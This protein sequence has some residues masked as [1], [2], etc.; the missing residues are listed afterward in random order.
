MR[1]I[2]CLLLLPL[3][4]ACNKKPNKMTADPSY[5]KDVHIEFVDSVYDFGNIDD[6]IP[7]PKHTFT[8]INSGTA[9]LIINSIDPSCGCIQ[10]LKYSIKPIA[11]GEKGTVTVAFDPQS[12]TKGFFS[13]T[14][15]IRS[16]ELLFRYVTIKGNNLIK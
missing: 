5:S 6:T 12:D 2:F 14:I 7:L 8:F 13:K 11:P 1:N 15:G 3:L 10:V 16:N 4:L 9:P